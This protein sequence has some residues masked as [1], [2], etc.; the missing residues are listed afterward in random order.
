MSNLQ[1]II[2][3]VSLVLMLRAAL[4]RALRPGSARR[5]ARCRTTTTA[6]TLMGIP[7]DRIISFTFVLG[8]ALAAAAGVLVGAA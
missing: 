7:V 2:L 1:L 6:A 5:C 8:S 4:D 3:V